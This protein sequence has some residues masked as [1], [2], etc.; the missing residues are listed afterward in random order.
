VRALILE[1][2]ARQGT[3][4]AEAAS[5]SL[6]KLR[7][8]LLPPQLQELEAQLGLTGSGGGSGEHDAEK[9]GG[10][11]GKNGT[12]DK[13]GAVKRAGASLLPPGQRH[14]PY[15]GA[16]L[17]APAVHS[18]SLQHTFKVGAGAACS[19]GSRRRSA[20]G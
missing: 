5:S 1:V 20:P 7:V 2:I 14:N 8:Q 17:E 19:G 4:T 6:P 15:E 16:D 3:T 11:G 18:Y 10:A 12:G 9:A 13:A